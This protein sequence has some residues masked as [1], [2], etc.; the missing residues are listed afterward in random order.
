MLSLLP[1]LLCSEHRKVRGSKRP[2]LDINLHKPKQSESVQ[3][4]SIP[5]EAKSAD[6][7]KVDV[8]ILSHNQEVDWWMARMESH[9]HSSVPTVSC[10]TKADELLGLALAM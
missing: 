8:A 2:L 7:W 9:M 4:A 5:G 3:L 6:T 10:S 1:H